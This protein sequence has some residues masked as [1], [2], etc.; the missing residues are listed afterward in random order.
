MRLD[1]IAPHYKEPWS[2]CRYL[3]STIET[4]KGILF[5]NIR[6]ILVNDGTENVL[7]GSA[8]NAM[9]HFAEYPF[10]VDYI[11]KEHGG[12]SAARNAGLEASDAD[13][14]MFCDADDGF[15]NNY[16]LHLIF[17]SMQEGFD[18]CIS[19]FVEETFDKDCNPQIV[20]HNEDLTFMHGKVYR[21]QFLIDNNLWFDPALTIHE[22]GYFNMLVYSTVQWLNGKVKKISTPIYLWCWNNNSV[23]RQNREDFVLRTYDHVIASRSAI[24]RV[25]RDR[26]YEDFFKASVCM[27]VLNSYYDFQKTRYHMPKNAKYFAA[28]EK[29]F[30]RFWMEYKSVFNGLTNAYVA[31]IAVTARANGVK[32]G[33]L[34]EQQDLKSF[35]K[36]IEYEVKA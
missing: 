13:Y 22:D 26:G 16:A 21:R 10:T 7:F 24:C 33:M 17:S 25:Q 12:V 8:E 4:Q 30:R 27:T 2:V 9:F 32:N 3:F 31:E 35:L 15:L 28:A 36:H 19:N 5:D 34:M 11:V 6:V 18:M 20:N 29:A 1:I 14:V 23:V